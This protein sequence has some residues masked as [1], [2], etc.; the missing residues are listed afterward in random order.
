MSFSNLLLSSKKYPRG[1]KW[2]VRNWDEQNRSRDFSYSCMPWGRVTRLP[3]SPAQFSKWL[4]EFLCFSEGPS[5]QGTRMLKQRT[6]TIVIR[7]NKTDSG[8]ASMNRILVAGN[9]SFQFTHKLSFQ[10]WI[11]T[12]PHKRQRICPSCTQKTVVRDMD[13]LL[14]PCLVVFMTSF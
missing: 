8:W 6:L 11:L 13:V 9:K 4:G 7:N 10:L 14:A 12:L 2:S 5:K 3:S 1:R